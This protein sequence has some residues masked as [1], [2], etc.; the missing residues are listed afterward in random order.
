MRLDEVETFHDFQ[1]ILEELSKTN[2]GL[3]YLPLYIKFSQLMT[4]YRWILRLALIL[5]FTMG[6]IVGL[7]MP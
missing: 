2:A 3:F 5:G 6:L 1:K 4:R 7:L